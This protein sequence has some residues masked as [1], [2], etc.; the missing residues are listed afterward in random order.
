[1]SVARAIEGGRVVNQDLIDLYDF[2]GALRRRLILICAIGIVFAII[3][4]IVAHMMKPVYRTRA[5][6]DPVTSDTNPLTASTVSSSLSTLGGTLSTLVGGS[7]EV[8]RDI[9][10]AM[11]VLQSRAFTEKFLQQNNVMPLLFP[12]LWDERAG[13]W[14]DG[15]EAPTLARGFEAFQ[16]IRLVDVDNDNEFVTLQIDWTDRIKAAEWTNGMIRMLNEDLRQ[17]AI[18]AA[19]A[20]LTYLRDEFA[21]TDDTATREAISRLIESQLRQKMLATVTPEFELRFVDKAMV[22]DADRPVRPRKRIM[23]A[24][25]FVFGALVGVVVSLLLYRRELAGAGRL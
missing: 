19:D 4:G 5:T 9:D 18:V 10:E 14:K 2:M 25:G 22:P 3:M 21:K 20:S 7:S 8:D 23:E 13:R 15:V 17:R 11:T 6:L 12:K 1:M 24:L 16:K